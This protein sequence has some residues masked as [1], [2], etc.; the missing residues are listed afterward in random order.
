MSSIWGNNLRILIFGESHGASIGATIEGLPAGIVLDMGNIEKFMAR[1]RPGQ[2]EFSTARKESDKPEIV[3][4]VC[5]GI[6]TGAPLTAIIRNT[7]TR[8]RDYAETEQLARPSHADYAAH[9]KYDGKNDKRGGG[10]FS[11]RLTAPLVFVGAIASQLLSEKGI[12]VGCH[13]KSI[14]NSSDDTFGV[15]IDSDI[16]KKLSDMTFPV[17]NAAIGDRMKETI[18]QARSQKDSVGG[19]IECAIIGLPAGIG[20]P[21]FDGVENKIASIMFG[22]PAVKGIEFGA[23]FDIT[24]LK[25]S[26]ANDEMY[27]ENGAIKCYSNNNGGITGGITNGMPVV[28]RVAIKPTPSIAKAQRTVNLDTMQNSVI[29]IKGRHDPCIVQRA[30]PVV[31]A[32]AAIAVLD[33]LMEEE[34]T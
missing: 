10:H 29:E 8:S 22:M 32:A 23:G 33:M 1:R 21:M 14:E 31:E 2:N 6:T 3:S 5:D 13:I 24:K 28:F 30:A 16:L 9:I 15:E 17:I 26:A 18:L 11:G 25:G 20:E 12:T 19:I 34:W 7:D 27:V 4:G